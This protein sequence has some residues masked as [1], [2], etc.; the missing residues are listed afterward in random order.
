MCELA[1]LKE[2][3]ALLLA[4]MG[5]VA[6]RRRRARHARITSDVDFVAWRASQWKSRVLVTILLI[7]PLASSVNAQTTIIP[8]NPPLPFTLS[9]NSTTDV[10]GGTTINATGNVFFASGGSAATVPT[11]NI[12]SGLG[13]PGAISITTVP[14]TNATVANGRPLLKRLSRLLPPVSR[15]RSLRRG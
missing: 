9:A 1:C 3:L 11:L 12:N 14:G 2:T 15:W 6:K 13:T 4:M 7:A 8:P 5:G 10:E